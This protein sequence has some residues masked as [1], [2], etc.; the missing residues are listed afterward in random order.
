MFVL[1][2]RAK[3]LRQGRLSELIHNSEGLLNLESCTVEVNFR[4]VSEDSESLE[5]NSDERLCVSRTAYRNN[6]NKYHINGQI[7]NFAE[8]T[9]LLKG[10]GVDLDHKRFLILQGEVESIAQ[11]KAK[12]ANEHEEGLLEYLEDII[13]TNKYIERI[14]EAGKAV[15]SSNDMCAEKIVRVKAAEKEVQALT[16]EKNLAESFIRKDNSLTM[17]KAELYHLNRN[18]SEKQVNKI[19]EKIN[20]LRQTLQSET[21]RNTEKCSELEEVETKLKDLVNMHTKHNSE[22]EAVLKKL[23]VLEKEDIKLQET[24][25]HLKNKIK[26]LTKNLA[27]DCK[28]KNNTL[29]E[30]ADIEQE[31]TVIEGELKTLQS[32]YVNEEAELSAAT[33]SLKDKTGDLQTQLENLQTQLAPWTEKICQ[34]QDALEGAVLA[35]SVFE[36]KQRASGE[37][38]AQ[39]E[40]QL[41]TVT[42]EYS[43]AQDSL[44]GFQTQRK[45]LKAEI[46]RLE[47]EVSAG[48]EIQNSLATSVSTIQATLAEANEAIRQ[49]NNGSA[50]LSALMREGSSGRIKGVHGRLGDLGIIDSKYDCAISTA[51]SSLNYI[52]VEDTTSGQKCVEFLRKNNLGRASFIILEKMRSPDMKPH[53]PTGGQRLFDLVKSKDKK[54]LPAFYYGLNDT[55]VAANMEEATKLAYNGPRRFRVVTLDGKLIDTS[56]TMSGGG[57]SQQHGGMKASFVPEISSEQLAELNAILSDKLSQQKNVK[58]GLLQF[59]ELLSKAKINLKRCEME[60]GKLEIALKSLPQQISDLSDAVNSIKK[61]DWKP[62]KEDLEKMNRLK[63]QV[64]QNE[65]NIQELKESSGSIQKSIEACQGQ[66]LEAGGTRFKAQ[67]SKVNDLKDQIKL[68]EK[69]LSKITSQKAAL[70]K[71]SGQSESEATCSV[72]L[73]AIEQELKVLEEKIEQNTR[74]AFSIKQEC[75][76][77]ER[78]GEDFK[79]NLKTLKREE[80][81][82]MKELSKFRRKEFELKGEIE[83]S[84]GEVQELTEKCRLYEN[85]LGKLKLNDHLLE[86]EVICEIPSQMDEED[87]KDINRGALE[88]EIRRLEAEIQEMRPNLKVL[89]EYK[90]KERQFQVQLEEY[91]AIEA[92]RDENRHTFEILRKRRL[93][94]FMSGFRQISLRLKE[95]YQLITMGGNAELELVDSLDPF[96]EGILFS[97]MPPKKSWKNISNL[98]G[99]EKTLSSLALVFALHTFKPTPIYVMDEIDAA[100]DFRNVSIVANYLKERTKDAQFIVISLRNNMFELADRLVGIYKTSQKTRSVTIDPQSFCI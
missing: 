3:K 6:S 41:Q 20:E 92:A 91:N 45:D 8:V 100:L 35:L 75:T 33:L 52:V 76:R 23:T 26:A 11:M 1:G 34:E 31:I 7:S 69:R 90:Q 87:L 67:R 44:K 38:L 12:A 27:D 37:E 55:L 58:S 10:H 28:N 82:L 64:M 24:R 83:K 77:L 70:E 56:G 84:E 66:I 88:T 78:E 98:S 63:A 80:E 93:D 49:G 85:L 79:E 54:F 39:A 42:N 25:K 50:A 62:S 36:K 13:G 96:T 47:S 74:E 89:D 73:E 65:L 48:E 53:L 57:G 51:C 43:Q 22:L 97:V 81:L 95:L 30:I 4:F 71:K 15:D 19:S 5:P 16:E 14:D 59:Q 29:K 32:S 17:K 46:E 61:K 21:E 18:Q 94:E 72:E 40:S 2:Y 68:Q 99:G 86:G 9:T 60:I